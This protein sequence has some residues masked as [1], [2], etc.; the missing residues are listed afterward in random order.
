MKGADERIITR[1]S[2]PEVEIKFSTKTSEILAGNGVLSE[3][4]VGA[5]RR[6]YFACSMSHDVDSYKNPLS[7]DR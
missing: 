3:Y 2:E 5:R 1:V 4:N 7:I 6:K